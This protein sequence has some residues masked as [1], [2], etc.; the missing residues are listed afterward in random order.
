M[1]LKSDE[2]KSQSTR[3]HSR[4][5]ARAQPLRTDYSSNQD[6]DIHTTDDSEFKSESEKSEQKQLCK[7]QKN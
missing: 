4:K 3:A 1:V 2:I 6:R 5:H 7:Q